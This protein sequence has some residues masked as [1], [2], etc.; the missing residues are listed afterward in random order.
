MN[1]LLMMFACAA[2]AACAQ[3]HIQPAGAPPRELSP[4]VRQALEASGTE[5][6]GPRSAAC[7]I[8]L[9]K[10]A[11]QIDDNHEQNASFKNIRHG[12]LLG[13]IRF[14]AR[15]TDRRGQTIDAGVYTMRLSFFPANAQHE[16][17]S[18]TRDF[19]LLAPAADDRDLNSTPSFEELVK[20]SR[21]VSGTPHPAVLNV[22]KPEHAGPAVLR[23]EGDDWVLYA[24]MGDVP[25]AIL[26][27]GTYMQ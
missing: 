17:I 25:I 5:I 12:T 1:K 6:A 9:R 24:A 2:A 19:V 10:Q 13:A 26:V 7:E 14:D 27:I 21:K 20:M 3:Y 18:P 16:G 4:E 11:P 23:R 22:W 8:W 15:A